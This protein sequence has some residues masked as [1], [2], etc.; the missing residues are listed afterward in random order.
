ML[1]APQHSY[2]G[3]QHGVMEDHLGTESAESSISLVDTLSRSCHLMY[4][5]FAVG[6]P[7]SL[8]LLSRRRGLCAL[9]S[10]KKGSPTMPSAL[11]ALKQARSVW[12]SHRF[13]PLVGRLATVRRRRRAPGPGRR[14][15]GSS[16]NWPAYGL[17]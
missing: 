5:N 3:A 10:T 6:L 7:L 11:C 16:V 1:L 15:D 13:S 14:P 9:R 2:N 12:Q 17:S 4:I 8:P